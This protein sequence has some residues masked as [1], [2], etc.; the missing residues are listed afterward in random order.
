MVVHVCKIRPEV[1]YKQAK[2]ALDS[3]G[4]II[5][6][7]LFFYYIMYMNRIVLNQ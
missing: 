7:I 4:N 3:L 5:V 6:Y 2:V 1:L